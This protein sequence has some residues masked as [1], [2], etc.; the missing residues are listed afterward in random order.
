MLF[1]KAISA[2]RFKTKFYRVRDNK[3]FKN[4]SSKINSINKTKYMK[5]N[6]VDLKYISTIKRN[7]KNINTYDYCNDTLKDLRKYSRFGI[8]RTKS[9]YNNIPLNTSTI[10]KYKNYNR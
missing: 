7:Y 5:D 10:L 4:I 9:Y 3:K 2:P 1:I 8:I 6:C